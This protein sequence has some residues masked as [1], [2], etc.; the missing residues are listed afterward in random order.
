MKSEG[1]QG[2]ETLPA[3][4]TMVLPASTLSLESSISDLISLAASALRCARCR[5]SLATTAKPRPCSPAR[6]ASTAAFS[7]RMLVWKAM[8]SITPM[9]SAMRL[10][11][12]EMARM[13]VTTSRISSP[14]PLAAA[15]AVADSAAAKKASAKKAPAK[16]TPAKTAAKKTTAA[17]KKT[18]AAKK[19]PAKKAAKKAT[20]AAPQEEAP[21]EVTDALSAWLTAAH[22]A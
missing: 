17:A 19:A 9:I 13:V 11:E 16:K 2:S 1:E 15:L 7:A 5:T 10:L 3:S 12:S 21:E 22:P 8:P 20:K 14:P 18:T 6:A 4:R